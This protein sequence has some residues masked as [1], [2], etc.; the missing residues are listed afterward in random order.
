MQ[1]SKENMKRLMRY[2]RLKFEVVHASICVYFEIRDRNIKSENVVNRHTVDVSLDLV[3]ASYQPEDNT[4]SGIHFM[5]PAHAD[6]LHVADF[7]IALFVQIDLTICQRTQSGFY[8]PANPGA[9]AQIQQA[10]WSPEVIAPITGRTMP[11]I[12]AFRVAFR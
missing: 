4:T 10:S 8:V 2:G 6:L 1:E 5:V 9:Q 7:V 3:S 11:E 12:L